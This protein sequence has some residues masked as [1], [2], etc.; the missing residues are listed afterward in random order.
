MIL[1]GVVVF[2]MTTPTQASSRES[3]ITTKYWKDYAS[4][5]F[6]ECNRFCNS[7]TDHEGYRVVNSDDMINSDINGEYNRNEDENTEDTEA[8]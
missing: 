8:E 1:F 5:L 7:S 6:C 2:T 3:I 4:S